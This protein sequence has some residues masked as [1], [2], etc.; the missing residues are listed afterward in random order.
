MSGRRLHLTNRP[1]N[2][3]ILQMHR[4]AKT[5]GIAAHL[6]PGLTTVWGFRE[7]GFVE[8]WGH[9][10]NAPYGRRVH[11]SNRPHHERAEAPHH[12]QAPGMPRFPKCT[13]SP[14]DR[15]RGAL[16]PGPTTVW[17]IP[18]CRSGGF[19]IRRWLVENAPYMGSE[20]TS[21]RV[22]SSNAPFRQTTGVAAHYYRAPQRYGGTCRS[23]GFMI[24]RWLVE[25]ARYV[26]SECTSP[27]VHSSNAP[28]FPARS[29]VVFL[30]LVHYRM[31]PIGWSR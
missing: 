2:D 19:M 21:R 30:S 3:Q 4:F 9:G 13:F 6:L 23:G 20:C 11:S 26:G 27:R 16:L 14:N 7:C 15:S 31:H 29:R 18:P 22:H 28:F 17:G 10:K 8:R 25:N 1:R 12:A 24:R 5:I